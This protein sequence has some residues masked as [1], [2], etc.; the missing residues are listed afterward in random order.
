MDEEVQ[1]SEVESTGVQE[2]RG[3]KIRPQKAR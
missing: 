2:A 3:T 1:E